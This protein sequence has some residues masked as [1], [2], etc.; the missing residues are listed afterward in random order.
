M[1]NKKNENYLF[2]HAINAFFWVVVR[3][4]NLVNGVFAVAHAACV[5]K[6]GM[7]KS[8][9]LNLDRNLNQQKMFLY[10]NCGFHPSAW[11]SL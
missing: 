1:K 9:S 10:F 7:L 3:R 5:I 11:K 6:S 8:N 2:C 4:P